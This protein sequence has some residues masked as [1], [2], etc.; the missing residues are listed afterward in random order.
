V[1]HLPDGRL[2]F[3]GRADDQVKVRGFRIELGEVQAALAAHPGVRQAAVIARG[4]SSGERRL[5][6]Y[7]VADAAAA[8]GQVAAAQ[9]RGYL[10]DRLPDYMVPAAFVL[11]PALPL[12]PSGKLDRRA[13]PEPERAAAVP[14]RDL[15]ELA[16]VRLWEEILNV[17]PVGVSDDFFELGGHSLLAVRLMVRIREQFRRELPLASLFRARTIENLAALLRQEGEAPSRSALVEITPPVA[18][19]GGDAGERQRPFVCVHPA[20]GNVLCYAELARVLGPRQPFYG[21]QFPGV[22]GT[23]DDRSQQPLATIED[24]AAHYVAAVRAAGHQGPHRLGGWSLGGAVAYEMARQLAAAGEAVELLAMFDAP[25]PGAAAG[26]EE[27]ELELMAWFARDLAALS[28]RPI[29]V[30]GADLAAVPAGDRLRQVVLAAQAAHVLPPDLG[31]AEAARLFA[32]FRTTQRA[33]RAYTPGRYDGRVLLVLAGAPPGA[34]DE[35]PAVVTAWRSL[36]TSVEVEW[37]PGDHYSLVR[38]PRAA[39][40]ARLIAARLGRSMEESP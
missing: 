32:V 35:P 15:Q 19:A 11:L 2:C 8:G 24:M 27:E 31:P 17:R 36:A 10:R 38:P 21:L 1:R 6:A 4:G 20:G 40:L 25:P 13:L 5:V 33:L 22:D 14:P 26:W 9:L 34:E 37:V 7:V 28:G 23:G 18:A 12:T 39:H 3:L 30:S 16:L 29:A